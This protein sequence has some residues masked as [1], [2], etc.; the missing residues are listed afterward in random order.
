MRLLHG[1]ARQLHVFG[2]AD[3]QLCVGDVVRAGELGKVAASVR[4]RNLA[5]LQVVL[6]V[7]WKK[8]MV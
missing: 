6:Q 5:R 1:R 4:V 7:L 8:R 2:V 3:L